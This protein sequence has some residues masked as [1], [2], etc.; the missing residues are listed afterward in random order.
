M[1][2]TVRIH[3][4][5]DIDTVSVNP[6]TLELEPPEEEILYEGKGLVSPM[7]DPGDQMIGLGPR[8][9]LYYNVALPVMDC[10]IHVDDVLTVLAAANDSQL[11]DATLVIDGQVPSSITVYKRLRARLDEEAS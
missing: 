9:S 11:Q 8:T 4:P 10:D 7:G 2:D 6:V 3:R 1:V 5:V